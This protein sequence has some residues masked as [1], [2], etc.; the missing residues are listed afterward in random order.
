MNLKISSSIWTILFL[1]SGYSLHAQA[2]TSKYKERA[3]AV[4]QEV[5]G[6]KIPAFNNY[7]VPA[8]YANE[9][10]VIMARRA[11]IEA[12]SKKRMAPGLHVERS[13]YYNSTIRELVKINDK[14][15]LDEYSQFS[16]R[17]FKKLNRW[18]SATTTTFVGA[19][20][21]KPDGSIRQVGIDESILVQTAGSGP[22]RK[23]AISGLQV[24]DF[25]DI[26]VRTEEFSWI[27][28]EPERLTFEFGDEK[29]ILDYSIHCNIGD[30]YAVEY[31]S[32]NHAPDAQQTTNDDK[33]L[34]LDM[35]MKN[36][37][38]VP[39][40]LWMTPMRE[41]PAFRIN[42]LAGGKDVTGRSRGDVVKDVPL[43]DIINRVWPALNTA[44]FDPVQ[45][46]VNKVLHNYADHIKKLPPD[47][48]AR[49]IYY[50]YRFT[51][52]YNEMADENAM[53]VGQARNRMEVNTVTYLFALRNLL[54]GYDIK[55]EFAML[56]SRYG[57]SI[58]DVMTPGDMA[59]VLYVET[60]QP[61]FV[62]CENMFTCP[63][64][65]P[66]YLEGQPYVVFNRS[67]AHGVPPDLSIMTPVSSAE[68]NLHK[69]DMHIDIAADMQLLHIKR[70]TTLTGRMKQDEQLH[71]LNFEDCY[72]SE[73]QALHV[74]KSVMDELKKTRRRNNVSE[75]YA[76]ALQQARTSLKDR[77]KEEVASEFIEDPKEMLAWKIDNPGIRDYAADLVYS[78]EFTMDG[79]LQH[80]GNNLLLSVG[81]AINSPLKMTASQRD[82]KVDVYMPYARTLDCSI[83]FTIPPGYT[84]MGVEK[85][86]GKV[87]NDCGSLTT[88][89]RIQGNQLIVQYKRI[90][91]HN[92]E[93]AAKWPELLAIID[94]GND[95]SGQKVL[96]KKS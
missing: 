88:T 96:L 58:N 62:T 90:Y 34:I 61:F 81:K 56:P 29:P 92:F 15:S 4:D 73:Q 5:W 36:M 8:Q 74:E 64:Y 18:I 12:S 82:R 59:L 27:L 14:V 66:E 75:D 22:E 49:L 13:Y 51:R 46:Q 23:L 7:K 44:V 84:V 57:P 85:L 86:N 80:A 65:I 76:A 39:T 37:A 9:S 70:Q 40:D 19:R 21:I 11:D 6:W 60:P 42:I 10:S 68:E 69:E 20:I 47:S 17:Q 79:L 67:V 63:G 87:A 94:A 31:R 95:F 30:K 55:S 28:R 35:E 38:A 89:A 25:L 43:S 33:D 93:G 71:L 83:S 3:A 41:L 32:M 91:K 77:F 16:Y 50:A 72:A 54:N 45:E 2:D 1:A 78:T 48:L 26:Y 24:G 52:Y 53:E